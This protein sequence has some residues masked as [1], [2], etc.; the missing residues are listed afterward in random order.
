MTE[1]ITTAD[2]GV[3]FDNVLWHNIQPGSLAALYADGRY[4][5]PAIAESALGLTG[6]RRITVLGNYQIASIIDFEPG[7][8]AYDPKTLRRFTRGRRNLGADSIT[9]CDRADAAE[10]WHALTEG[11]DTNLRDYTLWWI[12]TLDGVPWT[13][14]ELAADLATNW[15]APIPAS[16]IWAN[17][18]IRG[19]GGTS[20]R[21]NLFLPFR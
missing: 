21:S 1:T 7:N 14:E 18:N 16:R 8:A 2:H 20:D 4:T 6:A 3:F 10:T 12:S 5:A 15:G 9:Y 11:T 17:Q 13:A 19:I